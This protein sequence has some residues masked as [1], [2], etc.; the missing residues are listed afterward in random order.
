MANSLNSLTGITD[1][2]MDEVHQIRNNVGADFVALLTTGENYCG[3]AWLMKPESVSFASSAFSVTD[4][5]CISHHTFAHELGHN[6]GLSHDRV[7]SKNNEGVKPYSFGYRNCGTGG[8]HTIMAYD[9][10]GGSTGLNYYST[11]LIQADGKV[12]GVDATDA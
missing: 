6:M 5:G 2:K 8:Y 12:I 7:T 3:I 1:G 11:P 10:P 9:C 4:V